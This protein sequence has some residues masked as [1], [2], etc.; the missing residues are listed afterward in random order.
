MSE[1]D[2]RDKFVEWLSWQSNLVVIFLG[3]ECLS[4]YVSSGLLETETFLYRITDIML[5]IV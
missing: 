5:F 1:T 3:P 4:K 2:N